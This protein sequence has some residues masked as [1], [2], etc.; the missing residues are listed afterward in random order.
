MKYSRDSGACNDMCI[1]IQGKGLE[2]KRY[3]SRSR[4]VPMTSRRGQTLLADFFPL[5]VFARAAGHCFIWGTVSTQGLCLVL[6][7]HGVG[8]EGDYHYCACNIIIMV[9][10][11][12]D[13]RQSCRREEL[14]IAE[15]SRRR[16]L[17][18]WLTAAFFFAAR[19][20]SFVFAER[21][22]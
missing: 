14:S 1:S 2:L 7:F 20:A 13:W 9:P 6:L 15:L 18:D 16:Y 21:S 4:D 22:T 5:R 17:L 8:P 11:R 19:W 10:V 3:L 12:C